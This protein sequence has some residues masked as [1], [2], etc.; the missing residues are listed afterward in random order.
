MVRDC[1]FAMNEME[2]SNSIHI[3][4]YR[5]PQAHALFVL[6]EQINPNMKRRNEY[7]IHVIKRENK[8][9]RFGLR[10]YRNKCCLHKNWLWFA[11]IRFDP[12][13]NII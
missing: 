3:L 5:K 4:D 10:Q 6:K 8:E 13:K 11:F 2:N 1:C 12:E 7:K 9:F